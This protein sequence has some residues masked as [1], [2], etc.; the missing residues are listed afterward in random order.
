MPPDSLEND[1]DDLLTSK[2]V[3]ARLR[4]MSGGYVVHLAHYA[5]T[6][7]SHEL[8]EGHAEIDAELSVGYSTLPS[9]FTSDGVYR[10]FVHRERSVTL[11]WCASPTRRK[12]GKK[13]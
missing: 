2:D 4:L 8:N 5:Q 3:I 7:M 11:G 1:F 9:R 13:R 12:G 6:R 10:P